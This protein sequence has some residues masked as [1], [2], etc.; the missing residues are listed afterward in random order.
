MGRR[1][2]LS[3]LYAALGV[4]RNATDKDVRNA[5]RKLA[6][7]FHPDHN[8]GKPEA[9]ERFKKV[10]AAYHILGDKEKRQR[11][12]RGEIDDDGNERAPF[13]P[14]GAGGFNGAGPFQNAQSHPFS[15]DDLGAFFSDIFQGGGASFQGGF[16]QGGP[17]MRRPQRGANRT[18]TLRIS[19][20]DAVLGTSKRITLPEAGTVDVK[21]PAGIEG[22]QTLRLSGKGAPG[23]GEGAPSGDALVTIEVSPSTVYKRE[24]R[25]LTSSV[26]VDLR[27]A[28]LGGKL[29]VPTPQ[30]SVTMKVPPHSDTGYKLRLNG[31]GVSAHGTHKAGDLFVTL[32]VKIG[33]V[34]PE[35]EAFLRS[36]SGAEGAA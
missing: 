14:H 12:D 27:T 13:G 23:M 9:E 32:H 8:A 34:D 16:G 15:G 19:F 3:D 31:R 30:G 26:A 5:Y 25:N 6:K 21:I 11:Y 17:Q 18:Y 2:R 7:Q 33:P 20:E 24:G 22:G 28:V 10:T 4:A 1:N 29:V 36:H 35:L